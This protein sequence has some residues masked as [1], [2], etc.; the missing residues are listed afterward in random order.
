VTEENHLAYLGHDHALFLLLDILINDL[1]SLLP[2]F[3]P[4]RAFIL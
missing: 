2:E 1:S 4:S 3:I